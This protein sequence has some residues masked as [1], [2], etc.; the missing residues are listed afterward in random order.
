V[1]AP[2]H[3]ALQAANVE[4]VLRE[5]EMFLVVR[6]AI[7]LEAVDRVTLSTGERWLSDFK[8]FIQRGRRRDRGV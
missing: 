7:E 3:G 5:V 6:G 2:V 8:V 1:P 4:I